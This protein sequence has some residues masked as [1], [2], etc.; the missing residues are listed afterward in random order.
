MLSE[1]SQSVKYEDCMIPHMRAN[2][3]GQT[4]KEK[5]NKTQKTKN[6]NG[7]FQGRGRGGRETRNY[8]VMGRVSVYKDEN[9]LETD[10]GDGCTTM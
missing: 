4:H 5:K 1:I 10:G 3:S 8:H 7:G 2:Q 9:V 6:Q